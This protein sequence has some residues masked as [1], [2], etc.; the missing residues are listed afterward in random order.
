MNLSSRK[1]T[2][3][4]YCELGMRNTK[5]QMVTLVND[6]GLQLNSTG[7]SLHT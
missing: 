3:L 5:D 4:G 7:K 6:V 1:M 2:S